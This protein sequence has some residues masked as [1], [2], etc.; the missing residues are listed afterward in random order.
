MYHRTPLTAEM[1]GEAESPAQGHTV[2]PW[3]SLVTHPGL[4][5]T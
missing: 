4:I 3:Q 5:Q 1:L 2:S